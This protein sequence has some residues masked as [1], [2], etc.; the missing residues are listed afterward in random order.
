MFKKLLAFLIVLFLY[1]FDFSTLPAFQIPV[2]K[3]SVFAQQQSAIPVKIQ[4]SK[5]IEPV[6]ESDLTADFNGDGVIN[7]IDYSQKL[8][9]IEIE[10]SV[11]RLIQ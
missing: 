8:K 11:K 10:E 6:V 2:F 4:R 3:L 9:R 1:L 5:L 7:A